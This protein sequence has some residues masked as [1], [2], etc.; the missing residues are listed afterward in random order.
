MCHHHSQKTAD[1]NSHTVQK[2]IRRIAF[3]SELIL[4]L[5]GS[6]DLDR[7]LVPGAYISVESILSGVG[8]PSTSNDSLASYFQSVVLPSESF[9]AIG[10]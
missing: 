1:H 5:S 4:A 9:I 3:R 6:I 10:S 2:E 8:F 7:D